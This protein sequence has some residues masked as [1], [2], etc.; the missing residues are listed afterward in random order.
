MVF[1]PYSER[2]VYVNTNQNR[3][4]LRFWL[5]WLLASVMGYGV[6]MLLGAYVAYGF[7]NR[8]PFDVT[9]G[10]TLGIVMGAAGGFAQW[11]VLR[12]RISGAG[13]WIL[14]SAM[15]F[16]AVF[17]LSRAVPSNNPATIGSIMAAAFGLVCGIPQ[18]LILR[19]TVARAG[20]W[21]FANILG[22]LAGEIGFPIAIAISATNDDLNMLVVALVFAA[23]YGAITGAALVWLLRQS[24]SSNIK[25]L[26]TAH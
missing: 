2:E 22:L 12:E 4:G 9:M 26:A 1:H 16:A 13:W 24:P 10:A 5:A 6:G 19:R 7:F 11:V 25:G 17:G 23:G 18:W 14:A 21:V 3:I 8:D 20:W 15:G